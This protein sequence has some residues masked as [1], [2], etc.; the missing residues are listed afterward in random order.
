MTALSQLVYCMGILIAHVLAMGLFCLSLFSFT[1][2][3][4]KAYYI[5]PDLAWSGPIGLAWLQS[6]PGHNFGL[7][8]GSPKNV[9]LGSKVVLASNLAS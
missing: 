8:V 7:K 9:G 1:S 4:G 2:C 5:K 3:S 6:W